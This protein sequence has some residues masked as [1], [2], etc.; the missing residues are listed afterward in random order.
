MAH[1]DFVIEEVELNEL[2]DIPSIESKMCYYANHFYR[3]GDGPSQFG[4][5]YKL[6]RDKIK[7]IDPKSDLSFFPP[8][9]KEYIEKH[10]NQS[11][12]QNF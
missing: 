8:T 1:P 6:A 4:Y 7:S 9:V 12:N 3:V 11:S 5:L 2:N 10:K